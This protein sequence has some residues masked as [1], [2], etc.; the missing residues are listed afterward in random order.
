MDADFEWSDENLPGPN[1]RWSCVSSWLE[2]A[3]FNDVRRHEQLLAAID[4]IINAIRNCRRRIKERKKETNATQID[5]CFCSLVL[6]SHACIRY[7]SR[8]LCESQNGGLSVTRS[9]L[10]FASSLG[11]VSQ[12]PLLKIQWHPSAF[13]WCSLR[14]LCSWSAPMLHMASRRLALISTASAQ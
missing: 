6:I 1:R 9:T 14:W 7:S 13:P 12:P 11:V 4:E 2:G 5:C 3:L 8:I 10:H